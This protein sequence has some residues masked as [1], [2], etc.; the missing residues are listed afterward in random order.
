MTRISFADHN[1][2]AALRDSE[3][4]REALGAL[5][6]AGI[7]DDRISVFGRPVGGVDLTPSKA[8]IHEPVGG[9]VGRE[10]A[11]GAVIGAATGGL[12]TALATAAVAALS[13][14]GPAVGP[15]ALI[16]LVAGGGAGGTVGAILGGEAGLRT[17]GGWQ[18]VRQAVAEG[19]VILAV[20]SD[21]RG[22]IETATEALES[23]EPMSLDR[24]NSLGQK[25]VAAD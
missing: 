15:G 1:L 18:Q 14:A 9:H 23:I 5:R 21:H 3:H 8:A 24:V 2:L 25:V 4:A 11:S 10:I 6:D 19:A 17:S 16:G 13:G 22:D 7:G 20:H 12:I